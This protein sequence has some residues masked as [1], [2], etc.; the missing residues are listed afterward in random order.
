MKLGIKVEYTQT[1]AFIE[2]EIGWIDHNNRDG[3]CNFCG[4]EKDFKNYM[5]GE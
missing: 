3:G 4:W 5:K 2:K 1:D